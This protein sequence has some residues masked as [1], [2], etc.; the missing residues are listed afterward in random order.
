MSTT[1]KELAYRRDG[2]IEVALFWNTETGSL[3]VSVA[4]VAS[5]EAFNLPVAPVQALDVFYHPY[6]YAAS[7]GVV[8]GPGTAATLYA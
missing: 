6:A 7:M 4:D 5:D 2:G 8:Y 3:I 1:T